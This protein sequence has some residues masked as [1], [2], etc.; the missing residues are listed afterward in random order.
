MIN[1]AAALGEDYAAEATGL[2]IPKIMNIDHAKTA[3]RPY[4][5][6]IDK[7][8][9]AADDLKIETEADNQRAVVLGT[10]AKKLAKQIDDKR[11]QIIADPNDFVKSVNSFA[12][13]FTD[14]LGVVEDTLKRKISQY[15]VAQEQKRREEEKRAREEAAKIQAA[16][17]ADAEKKGIEAPQVVAPIIPKAPAAVRTETGAASGRKVWTFELEDLDK[18]PREWLRLDEIKVRDAI[19]AGVRDIPGIRIFEEEKTVFR[20][21]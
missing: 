19:R 11:K 13:I 3:L 10:S 2:P 9:S 20:T 15:R 7:M 16:L 21:A 4:V 14:K 18:V 17:N 5:A 8:V 12:K 1:L 6:E